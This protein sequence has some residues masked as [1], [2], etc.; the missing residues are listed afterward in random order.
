MK[1]LFRVKS[2]NFVSGA[3]QRKVSVLLGSTRLFTNVV[4]AQNVPPISTV[5][6]CVK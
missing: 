4:F 3:T 6:F 2:V 1:I 5:S